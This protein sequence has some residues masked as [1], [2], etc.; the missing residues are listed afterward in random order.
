MD[1]QNRPEEKISTEKPKTRLK[2]KSVKGS[3]QKKRTQWFDHLE[4]ME[5]SIWSR[6]CR[7][8]KVSSS[9]P[10]RT[11]SKNMKYG[12]Q[13]LSERKESQSIPS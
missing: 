8:F 2:L 5:D 7:T 12:T 1:V 4:I 3:L 6:I 13:K 10:Q 9:F 11:K